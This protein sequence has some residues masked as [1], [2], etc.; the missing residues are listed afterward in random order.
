MAEGQPPPPQQQQQQ[1]QF[2]SSKWPVVYPAYI[3]A[4]KTIALVRRRRAPAHILPLLQP[5]ACPP[6]ACCSLCAATARAMLAARS[7]AG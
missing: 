2:D 3:D 7:A 4:G 6:A 5:A 1:Q